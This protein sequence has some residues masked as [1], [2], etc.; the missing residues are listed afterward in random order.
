MLLYVKLVRQASGVEI[1]VFLVDDLFT[2]RGNKSS[3]RFAC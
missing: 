1:L 3:A 2:A